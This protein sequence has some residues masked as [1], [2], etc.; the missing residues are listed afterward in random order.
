MDPAAVA[1]RLAADG[2]ELPAIQGTLYRIAMLKA[3]PS[4]L[5]VTPDDEGNLSG[6]RNKA[7]RDPTAQL[8]RE[9]QADMEQVAHRAFREAASAR[10]GQ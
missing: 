1:A 2:L 7:A 3:D 6:R 5:D 8:S 10:S 4:I 9:Q